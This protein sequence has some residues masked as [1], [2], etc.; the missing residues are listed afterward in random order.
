MPDPHPA[1]L[2]SYDIAHPARL[3]RVHRCVQAQAFQLLESLY[4]LVTP[5][6]QARHLWL[7]L[8]KITLPGQDRLQFLR[9]D[10]RYPLILAGTAIPHPDIMLL[11]WPTWCTADEYLATAS[12]R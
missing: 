7:Q 10:T 9:L 4:L 6:E 2:I 1:Y 3:R 12:Q 8:S 5:V 11:G